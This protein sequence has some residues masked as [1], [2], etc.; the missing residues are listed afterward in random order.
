V[1]SPSILNGTYHVRTTIRDEQRFGPPASNPENLH[2]GVETRVLRN[3][4]FR[5][6]V[7]EPSEWGGTYTI[8]GDRITLISADSGPPGL[9]FVFSLDRHGTLHLKPVLPMG[10][11]D[12]WV[13]AGEPWQRVGPPRPLG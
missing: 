6:A 11:G 12:Q 1:R 5:F 3:G 4:R 9:T 13:D 7:G 10:R 2:A 8:R